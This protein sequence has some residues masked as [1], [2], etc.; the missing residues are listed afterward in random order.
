MD[1][2]FTASGLCPL[3]VCS[4][5]FQYIPIPLAFPNSYQGFMLRLCSATC[6]DF[7]QQH[8]S[9]SLSNMLRLCSATA[10][11]Q[12]LVFIPDKLVAYLLLNAQHHAS[13]L[14]STMLRLCSATCF[15]FAQQ[16]GSLP[17][18][19]QASAWAQPNGGL[20]PLPVQRRRWFNLATGFHHLNYS[21]QIALLLDTIYVVA[22][23]GL[24]SCR[25]TRLLLRAEM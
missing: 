5:N 17:Q 1:H 9:T 16:H 23:C 10:F 8:A 15:D 11:V 6:F 14:L 3:C 18:H 24:L 12:L 2:R 13:T 21:M 7:A 22:D 25:A 20:P 19:L 4:A